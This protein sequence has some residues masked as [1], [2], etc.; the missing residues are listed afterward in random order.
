MEEKIKTALTIEEALRYF[1]NNKGESC[2]VGKI[3]TK[4]KCPICQKPYAEILIKGKPCLACKEHKTIPDRYFVDISW[5]GNRFKLYSSKMGVLLTSYNEALIT[6]SIIQA[7]IDNKTFDPINYKKAEQEK[8]Y[9]SKLLDKF[10]DEKLKSIKPSY[11]VAYK[12]FVK[13]HKSFFGNTD[14]RDIHKIDIKQYQDS[15]ELKDI[16]GKTLLNY[17][18]NFRVFLNWLYEFEI[19]E[20]RINYNTKEIEINPSKWSWVD[21]ETQIM[22]LNAIPEGDRPIFAFLMLHG[23]RPGE[24]RALKLK[25]YDSLHKTILIDST[26]SGRKEIRNTRKGRGAKS[27]LIPLHSEMLSYVHA[28]S[29]EDMLN[30]EAF[31]FINPRTGGHYAEDTLANIW[32]KARMKVGLSDNIRLYDVTRHSFASQLANG[33]TSPF[34]IQQLLGH[35]NINMT[36]RYMHTHLDSTRAVL[37]G[38]IVTL[39]LSPEC[40]QDKAKD[41][42]SINNH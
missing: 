20:N 25:H 41:K 2:M 9:A 19:I 27:L 22:I 7:D 13:V 23:C 11:H 6:L 40:P 8:Y 16:K 28:R 37:D 15:L 18:N 30:K 42:K 32:H 33:G 29:I 24:V 14:V 21:S 35:S 10:L 26:W 34:I 39:K 5:K 4:Q 36:N 1:I 3:R 17:I 38:G 12:L 31:L